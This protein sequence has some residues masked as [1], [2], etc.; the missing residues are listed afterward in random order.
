MAYRDMAN[1]QIETLLTLMTITIQ[2]GNVD[3]S[4]DEDSAGETVTEVDVDGFSDFSNRKKD[5]QDLFD[6]VF[7]Q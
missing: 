5:S 7:S 3:G 4:S 2:K 6:K 1:L